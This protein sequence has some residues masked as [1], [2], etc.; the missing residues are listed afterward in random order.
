MQTQPIFS[1]ADEIYDWVIGL[2]YS[3]T[4]GTVTSVTGASPIVSSGGVTPEISATIAKD[5]VTTAPMT[6]AVDNVFLGTDSDVYHLEFT[7]C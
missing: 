1:L 2:G 7:V 6:G 5:L 4:V 3:T